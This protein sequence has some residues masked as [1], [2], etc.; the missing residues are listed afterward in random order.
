M[1]SMKIT[2]HALLGFLLLAAPAAV[3]AQF[4]TTTN[5]V[6]NVAVSVNITQYSG[7]GGFVAIPT[8]FGNLPVAGIGTSAFESQTT[9]TGIGIPG[10]VTSI[11]VSAFKFCIGLTSLAIPG[12]VTSIDDG[13][14]ENCFK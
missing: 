9:V 5:Y 14:F 8:N 3:Q 6:S 10:S 7:P 11:G 12:S 2:I 13:A 4:S 1:P